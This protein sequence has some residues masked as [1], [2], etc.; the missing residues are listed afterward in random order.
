MPHYLPGKNPYLAEF[1][2]LHGL[3]VQPTRGGAEYPHM[4]KVKSMPIPAPPAR[5]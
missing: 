2:A 4:D 3:P 5:R 1:A